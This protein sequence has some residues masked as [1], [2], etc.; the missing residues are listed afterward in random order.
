[1]LLDALD[2]RLELPLNGNT[3]AIYGD[4]TCTLTA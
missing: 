1:M 3:F 2:T 4:G